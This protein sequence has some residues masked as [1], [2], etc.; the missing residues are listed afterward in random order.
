VLEGG[1]LLMMD[2]QLSISG[3][4]AGLVG[5]GVPKSNPLVPMFLPT[6]GVERFSVCY[7]D[8]GGALELQTPALPTAME[9]IGTLHWG[10]GLWGMSV[11]SSEK[12]TLACGI[13][14]MTSSIQQTPCGAIPDSG[15]TVLMGPMQQILSIFAGLC[16]QWPRCAAYNLNTEAMKANAFSSLLYQCDEWLVD[17]E[18]LSELPSFFVRLGGTGGV[19]QQSLELTPW[20]YIASVEKPDYDKVTEKL[21]EVRPKDVDMFLKVGTSKVCYP[22][23]GVYDYPTSTNG[24]VWILG[25]PLFYQYKVQFEQTAPMKIGFSSEPCDLCPGSSA[26]ALLEQGLAPPGGKSTG[27]LPGAGRRKLRHTS[28]PVRVADFNI[29]QPL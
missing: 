9:Q 19:D 24:Y 10:L 25:L 5:L 8:T 21:G 26:A 2:S 23:F 11:G 12:P 20:S 7:Q 27:G 28:K 14:E 6:A 17:D 22:M 29:S 1:V 18:G 4:F 3:L 15:T 13:D 16:D